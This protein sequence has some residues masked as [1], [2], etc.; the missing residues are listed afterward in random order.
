MIL[1]LDIDGVLHPDPTTQEFAFCKSYL[2]HELIR[3]FPNLKFVISSDWRK[4]HT[5]DEL[6]ELIFHNNIDYYEKTGNCKVILANDPCEILKH[7][8]YVINADIHTRKRTKERLLRSGAEKVVSGHQNKRTK[9][10]RFLIPIFYFLGD[11]Q[12]TQTCKTPEFMRVSTV[13]QGRLLLFLRL[14][15]E[16]SGCG[17]SLC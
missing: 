13:L 15:H 9:S 11:S 7:T 4:Y 3:E 8:K 17:K 6:R 14:R 16:S 1:F 10:L 12:P 2:L 5:L